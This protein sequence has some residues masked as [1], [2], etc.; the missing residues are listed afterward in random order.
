[1]KFASFVLAS[2]LLTAAA[3]PAATSK[4]YTGVITDTMCSRDHAHMKVSPESKCVRDCV[5]DGRTYKYALLTADG[6]YKLSDQETPAKF[7]A[8]RVRVTG[9][10]YEKTKIL[11]VESIEPA[12]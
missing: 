2:A 10:L 9:V 6:L 5:G 8:Q 1:M 7:A 11:K 4:T 3:P 12:K